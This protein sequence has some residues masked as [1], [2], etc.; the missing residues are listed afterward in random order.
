MRA[1]NPLGNQRQRPIALALVLE[2]VLA[3]KDGMGLPAPLP[4]QPCPGLQ[5]DAGIDGE[6]AFLELSREDIQTALERAVRAGMGALLQLIG[7]PPDDQIPT[8]A[9][10]R[11]AVMRAP[12][13]TPQLCCRLFEQSSKFAIKLGQVRVIAVLPVAVWT[14]NGRRLARLLASRG[15]MD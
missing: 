9:R 1:G 4:H 15:A 6:S 14:E 13:G 3:N 7:E 11:S 5:H 2:P 12:P 8:E 10:R